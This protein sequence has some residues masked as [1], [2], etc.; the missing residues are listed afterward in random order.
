MPVSILVIG[1]GSIG[2]RHLRCFQQIGCEV[3]LCETQDARREALAAQYGLRQTYAAVDEA[4]RQRWDGVVVCTPAQWHVDHALAVAPATRGLLIEKPLATRLDDVPRL[5][6]GTR[7]HVVQMAYVYRA[8]PATVHGLEVLAAGRL[9]APRQVTVVAGQHFPTFR[10]AYREIY[11][12]RRETGGGAIQDAATHLFD[13]I[14]AFV[15]PLDWV[16]CDCAH[17]QLPGV[18][19]E[20]T[21]HLVARAS[22]GRVLVSLAL[23]QFMAPNELHFQLNASEGSLAIRFH[24]HRAGVIRLGE[25]DWTWTEPLVRERDELFRAQAQSFLRALAGEPPRCTLDDGERAL[26]VNLA[27]LESAARHAPIATATA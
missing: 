5:R 15:G 21:V 7:G 9:G 2:E 19:V 20:D 27:A 24:E 6:A 8:H 14:Q 1:G 13:L 3:A 25:S 17:Q 22:G 26:R 4:A 18:E 12:A 10:P 11:Y 16:F 23:N